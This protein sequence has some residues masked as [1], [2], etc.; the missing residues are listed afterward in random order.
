MAPSGRVKLNEPYKTNP[1]DLQID[2]NLSESTLRKGTAVQSQSSFQYADDY[3][4]SS[5]PAFLQN[6]LK[7]S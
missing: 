3:G 7:S 6:K 5:N 2:G 4:V 1:G